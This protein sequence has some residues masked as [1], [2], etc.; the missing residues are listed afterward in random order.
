V[1]G[2]FIQPGDATEAPTTLRAYPQDSFG[3]LLSFR[4][5]PCD[6]AQWSI[7]A[8]GSIEAVLGPTGTPG[9]ARVTYNGPGTYTITAACLGLTQTFVA[10]V[11]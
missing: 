7:T 3:H 10:T 11:H 8:P 2:I 1:V 6:P 5:K 9:F 4:P